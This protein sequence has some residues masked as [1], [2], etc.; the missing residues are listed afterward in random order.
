MRMKRFTD[1]LHENEEVNSCS[2]SGVVLK[3]N[4]PRWHAIDIKFGLRT[5]VQ[6]RAHIVSKWTIV[7]SRKPWIPKILESEEPL[8]SLPFPDCPIS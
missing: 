5:F 7:I 8:S 4:A 1:F 2:L 3:S 6:E